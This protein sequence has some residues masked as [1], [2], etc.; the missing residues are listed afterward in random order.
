[1]MSRYAGVIR[2]DDGLRKALKVMDEIGQEKI[3]RLC[4]VGN[5]SFREVAGLI[6]ALNIHTV[7]RLILQAALLRTESRGSHNREDYPETSDVWQ[8]NIVFQRK[9]G[10]TDV[11]IKAVESL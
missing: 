2:D 4:I 9:A 10:K 8:K 11:S 6:E 7:G 3:D 5:H 1:L